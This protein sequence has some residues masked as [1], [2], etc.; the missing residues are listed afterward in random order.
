MNK[1]FYYKN[2]VI[3]KLE[4][5]I[6]SKVVDPKK[7]FMRLNKSWG[8]DLETF[9]ELPEDTQIHLLDDTNKEVYFT[10]WKTYADNGT[11]ED[12][13]YGRQIFLS[14]DKFK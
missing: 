10:D 7:H 5:G 8:I 1:T 3:G 11:V 2:K 4:N 13:G 12:F 6:F 9:K 14:K